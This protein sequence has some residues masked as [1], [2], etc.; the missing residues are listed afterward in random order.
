MPLLLRKPTLPTFLLA[1]LCLATTGVAAQGTDAE[2]QAFQ[3]M[4]DSRQQ[5]HATLEREAQRITQAAAQELAD[6]VRWEAVRAQ[7]LEEMRDMLGLLPWPARTPLNLRVT[8]V[9]DKGSYVIEKIAFESM[10]RVYVTGNLYLP[11]QRAQPVPAIVYV[12]G[13][14][15]SPHG[16][17]AQ[18]QRHGISFAKNGYAAFILDSIQIAETFALHHGLYSQEMFDWYA[19]GYTP[20]GVEV[21]NAMRAIDYLETRAEVDASRIGMT[22]RSGGAAMS[23]FTAAVDPRVKVVVPVMGISTYAANLKHDTQKGHCDCMFCIN[24]YK[25]DMLHQGALIAPRPLLMA[26]GV[27]DDLFPVEGYQEFERII[28]RLYGGYGEGRKFRNIEVDTGHQDSDFLRE[29]AIRFFDEHLLGQPKR[30]LDMDYSNADPATLAVFAGQ[31]PAD[32]ENYRIHETFTTRPPSGDFASLAAWQQ[33]RVELLAAVRKLLPDPEEEA[34]PR[35]DIHPR[36]E[37]EGK[38]PVLVYVASPGEDTRYHNLLLSGAHSRDTVMRVVVWPRGV[39]EAPWPRI[40]ERDALRNAMH[41]GETPD[42]L[43][44]RDVRRA[45]RHVATLP[46]A[47]GARITIAGRG[48]S[49][50]LG[51]YAA[52]LEP[53]VQQVILMDAPESHR[54]GPLFLNILRHTDLPEA[55]ALLAPRRLLFYGHMPAAYRYTRHV[56]ALHGEPDKPD[57]TMHL[58]FAAEGQHGH[59]MASGW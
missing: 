52:I 40:V 51:M 5:F 55:A 46:G 33:R 21:W 58:H 36:R 31:P 22:G 25:H 26:H 1:V 2:R 11:K 47:D 35:M 59:G 39:Q 6:P 37:G 27:K 41:V 28:S 38:A 15:Y 8:G 9:L 18:Y 48:N 16:D 13:H 57:V 43:R 17:K 54:Q 23:F 4:L 32:A 20:A 45:L 56:Y 19:R 53:Y 42:S 44:L 50:I 29:E 10:P 49:G 12:C 30:T 34:L 3:R 7:R 24:T 14:S